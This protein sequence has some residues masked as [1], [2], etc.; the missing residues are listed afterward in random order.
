M[1]PKKRR[2]CGDVGNLKSILH[3][4][5]ISTTGLAELVRR[6]RARDIDLG[7][8][9]NWSL[10]DAN[11]DLLDFYCVV[12]TLPLVLVVN[13]IMHRLEWAQATASERADIEAMEAAE[14]QG[15]RLS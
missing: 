12:D 10:R 5:S 7:S 13:G 2:R 15:R 9:S 4:G 8:I 14:C 11:Y 6:L 3:T 1:P